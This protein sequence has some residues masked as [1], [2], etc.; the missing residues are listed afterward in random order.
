MSGS[1]SSSDMSK[2]IIELDQGVDV[3]HLGAATPLM[4][5]PLSSTVS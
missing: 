4:G 5:P 1:G 2:Y 3:T